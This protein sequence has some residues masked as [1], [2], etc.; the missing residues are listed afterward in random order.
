MKYACLILIRDLQETTQQEHTIL[1]SQVA[2]EKL[3]TKITATRADD[4][5]NKTEADEH[6]H[7]AFDN[8]ANGGGGACATETGKIKK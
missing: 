8:D 2:A 1:V 5:A 3:A 6:D 4:V 7:D